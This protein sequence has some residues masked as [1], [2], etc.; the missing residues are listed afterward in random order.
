MPRVGV[1]PLGFED[2]GRIAGQGELLRGGHDAEWS[3]SV[4]RGI[5]EA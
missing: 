2:Q 4:S 3:R 1:D 5:D